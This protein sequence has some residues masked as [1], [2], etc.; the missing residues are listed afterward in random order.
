MFKFTREETESP[1]KTTTA[2]NGGYEQTPP[3]K[4]LKSRPLDRPKS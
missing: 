2:L 4:G 1:A 3:H